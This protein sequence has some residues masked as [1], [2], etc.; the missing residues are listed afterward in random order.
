MISS[1]RRKW[2]VFLGGIKMR[3]MLKKETKMHEQ[4]TKQNIWVSQVQK[5]ISFHHVPGYREIGT[6]DHD[7][8]WKMILNLIDLGY[9]VG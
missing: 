4:E 5:C 7:E 2:L 8:L 6:F 9:K 3:T 1:Y